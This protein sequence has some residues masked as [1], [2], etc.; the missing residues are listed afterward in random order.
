MNSPLVELLAD[1]IQIPSVNPDGV[2]GTASVGEM[3][4]AKYLESFLT[5]LGAETEL[6]E[7]LPGRPNVVARFPSDR[8][9]KPRLLFAPHTDTV[10]VIGMTIAPFSGEVRE[11]KVWGRGASD[12]KGPMA[13]MLDA[14]RACRSLLP[15]LSHEIWFAGLM[16]EET[17][18]HGS[19][20]L[21]AEEYFD[22]V[23]AGEPT[24]LQT[25]HTHKGAANMILRTTGRAAHSST[26][27]DGEN[28][29]DKMLDILAA[30]RA[31]ARADF[32]AQCDPVLG[33][34]TFSIGIVRGGSKINIVP[35]SCE[36]QINI[37]TIPGQD[38]Q[39]LLDGLIQD[40]P[41]LEI[42]N[43]L[44]ASL[45]TDPAH[46]LIRTLE[47][48]GAAP[49]G[50][51]WFCDGALFSAA[52]MAAVALGPGSLAQAHTA[53]EWISIADLEKGSA[54]FQNFLHQLS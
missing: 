31:R 16:G 14:L 7:V 24:N 23:I 18:Q 11:G 21:A 28:A 40:F 46:P 43:V 25:V 52:G 5:E 35:D 10:S 1:L 27:Q 47:S 33:P 17:G 12:T 4:C 50:A 30:F 26:P 19:R 22:F 2:P 51:P 42:D 45:W 54:F 44:S 9:G 20:A 48:C 41:G 49:I 32:S 39:P 37:R 36:A 6:R 53:D 3:A 34:P 8:P 15:E 13:A 29:I 38:V